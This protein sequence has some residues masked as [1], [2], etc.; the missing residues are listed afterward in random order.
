MEAVA[1]AGLFFTL[2]LLAMAGVMVA[3]MVLWVWAFADVVR[4]PGDFVFK[5]GSKVLW[6]I[7]VGLGGPMGA[8]IYMLVGR[9]QRP[10]SRRAY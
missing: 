6:A 3:G 8:L 10:A 5:A 2:V 1:A 7:V 4:A 9:A